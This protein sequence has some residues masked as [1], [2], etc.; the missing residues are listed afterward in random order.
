VEGNLPIA[1][2]LRLVY[3]ALAGLGAAHA[4]GVVHR[5]VKP[6]NLFV[7]EKDLAVKGMD[8]GIATSGEGSVAYTE[9]GMLVGTPAYVA[10]E[11]LRVERDKDIGPSV[12]IYSLGVVLYRL[13]AGRLPFGKRNVAARF[14]DILHKVPP[15]PSR[16]NPEISP[17]LDAVV[18]RMIEK[19]PVQRYGTCK[20]CGPPCA[21]SP[22]PG[23]AE[24]LG[25]MM[26]LGP[27]AGWRRVGGCLGN[28]C[29]S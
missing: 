28:L 8:F 16:F 1:V 12:D 23:R 25:A 29:C 18:M 22:G 7:I 15:P 5:D 10:P 27:P 26:G 2:S 6:G 4:E 14:M 13:L 3:Q 17:E 11:R 19:D 20:R 21:R 9:T 24:G